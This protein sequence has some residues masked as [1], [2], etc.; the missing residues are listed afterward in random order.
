MARKTIKVD[1]LA[2]VEGEGGA[3][4]RVRRRAV[5]EVELRIFEPPRFFEALLR[6]R[7][8]HARRPT[9]PRGSAAS[10]RSPTR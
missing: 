3:A 8:L 9:S 2:R 4:A 7:V 10:V 5:R 1:Y 6:G